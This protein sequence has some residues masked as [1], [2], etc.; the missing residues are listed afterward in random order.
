MNLTSELFPRRPAFFGV[1]SSLLILSSL[2]LIAAK[3]AAL[4]LSNI[5]EAFSPKALAKSALENNSELNRC[6]Y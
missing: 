1:Q 6:V 4:R 2:R 3:Q 5:S